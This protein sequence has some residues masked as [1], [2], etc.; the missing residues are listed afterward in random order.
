MQNYDF[1]IGNGIGNGDECDYL[2]EEYNIFDFTK[3]DAYVT[4]RPGKQEEQHE[5]KYVKYM[6]LDYLFH[7][8]ETEIID[9]H[10]KYTTVQYCIYH[11]NLEGMHPFLQ[12]YFDDPIDILH[13]CEKKGMFIEQDVCIL[14]YEMKSSMCNGVKQY[15]N[16]YLVDEFIN[17]LDNPISSIS[18]IFQR[19]PGLFLLENERNLVYETPVVGYREKNVGY[20]YFHLDQEAIMGPY[21]YFRTRKP[22]KEQK[23]NKEYTKFSLFLGKTKVPMNFPKDDYDKSLMK[24]A[25][26]R[27]EQEKQNI[28][29]KSYS[30]RQTMRISDH[31]GN[32]TLDYDSVYLGKI[33]LDDGTIL[34]EKPCWV[35][36][37]LNQCTKL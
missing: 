29:K 35:I 6:A 1:G 37:N 9:L 8:E 12:F 4:K 26:L 21:Y 34:R 13:L 33:E 32:W 7:F 27:E 23:Q 11:I 5:D 19:N 10:N 24:Q 36:K 16:F 22:K 31:D 20:D 2:E 25:L 15:K 18:N 28:A 30:I 3:Q 17:H 14:F